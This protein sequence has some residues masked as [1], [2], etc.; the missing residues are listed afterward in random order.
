TLQTAAT[1]GVD[2]DQRECLAAPL[3]NFAQRAKAS[4]EIG[5][6]F[7]E[8]TA[9]RKPMDRLLLRGSPLKPAVYLLP[10]HSPLRTVPI[11]VAVILCA[12][13]CLWRSKHRDRKRLSINAFS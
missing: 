12:S 10:P 1:A 2:S 8:T 3:D 6:D 5:S 13:V 9:F 4:T 7:N 11:I